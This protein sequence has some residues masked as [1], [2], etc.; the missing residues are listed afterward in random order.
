MTCVR[1]REQ[2]LSS[3]IAI[4]FS[5]AAVIKTS[6]GADICGKAGTPTGDVLRI[7]TNASILS[8][9]PA[10]LALVLFLL[11]GKAEGSDLFT[12]L[13]IFPVGKGGKTCAVEVKLSVLVY[14]AFVHV[15]CHDIG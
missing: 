7:L 8:N 14:K 5:T 2:A 12:Q 15:N 11:D 9:A 13:K 3:G 6:P 10:S 1:Q 4:K